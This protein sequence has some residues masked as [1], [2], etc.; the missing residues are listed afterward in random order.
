MLFVTHLAA[1]AVVGRLSRLPTV[2][3]AAGAATPDLIDKPLGAA[4]VVE[5]YHSIGHSALV[6]AVLVPLALYSRLGVAVALGWASHLLFDVVHVVLNGRPGHA[7]FLLWP[8]ARSSDPLGLPPVAFVR[9]YL[10]T[11]S[12]YLEVVLWLALLA[13]FIWERRRGGLAPGMGG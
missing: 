3:L 2:P 9:H 8:L 12:F 7:L 11:P 10:W 1:A 5:L 13:V 4:G 6:F